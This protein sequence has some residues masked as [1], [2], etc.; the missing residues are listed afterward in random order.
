MPVVSWEVHSVE[1][2]KQLWPYPVKLV[3]VL[4]GQE[5]FVPLVS[6][7]ELI[8][9]KLEFL[10]YFVGVFNNL[11]ISLKLQSYHCQIVKLYWYG[12][13][14]FCVLANLQAVSCGL[15]ANPVDVEILV[16]SIVEC[17]ASGLACIDGC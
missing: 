11:G 4:S 9:I 2:D 17:A 13:R 7:V 12:C 10:P 3:L 14:N 16:R 15:F 8:R 5:V 6:P 1:Q